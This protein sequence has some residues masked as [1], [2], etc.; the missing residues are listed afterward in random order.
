MTIRLKRPAGRSRSPGEV[1]LWLVDQAVLALGREQRLDPLPDFITRVSSRTWTSATRATWPSASALRGE[2]RRR[3]RRRRRRRAARP[4][5][6]AQALQAGAVLQPGDRGRRRRRGARHVAAARQPDQLQDAR[7]GRERPRPLRLRHGPDR[8]AAAGHRAAGAAALRAPG[9]PLHGRGD[10]PHR[11]GRR[12]PGRGEVRAEG[13]KLQGETTREIAWVHEPARAHRVPGR[14]ADAAVRRGGQARVRGRDV[15][16]RRRAHLRRGRRRLRGRGCRCATIASGSSLRSSWSSTPAG[17]RAA[18]GRRAGAAGHRRRSILVST[19]PALVRMAAG[20]DSSCA[21]PYGCTEQRIEPRARGQIALHGFRALLHQE[22]GKERLER[23]VQDDAGVDPAAIDANG[24]V[25]YWPGSPGY[26]RSPPGRCSSWSRRRRPATRS[27]R[28]SSTPRALARAGAALGLQPLHRRR[29]LR[30][31]GLGARGPRAGRDSTRPTRR[32]SRARRSSST[33]RGWPRSCSPLR[34][35]RSPRPPRLR[36]SAKSSGT[37]S[38]SASTRAAR[39]TAACR[40]GAVA[41]RPD[42]AERDAHARRDHAG[43]RAHRTERQALTLL[44][45]ALVTLGRD[46]GW[47]TT[48]ANAAAL[49]ALSEMLKPP[50]AAS[51]HSQ[52]TLRADGK[53]QTLAL[54]PDAPSVPG[55]STAAR[56]RPLRSADRG[57]RVVVRGRD[58]LRPGGRRQPGGG[59]S[60][61]F[62]VTRELLRVRQGPARCRRR[63]CRRR[64]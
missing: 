26:V 35:P 25:A 28:S 17:R 30:R 51:P 4:R 39:S 45:D 16:G 1:T 15:Q 14:R 60:A 47:G 32:S 53:E 18:G 27:T 62:V 49:L 38:S 11:R 24:L 31:A 44:V 43:A 33:S 61:G 21:Y 40:K 8:G 56:R 20:L 6:R 46:D 34:G 2:P 55:R 23:A 59:A 12:R 9:R 7:Q 22:G 48:N 64:A 57:A 52:V 19:Q 54:G 41:Q 58:H 42:P 29:G 10:R 5:H 63:L 13:V 50:F 36:R 37:A 3:R